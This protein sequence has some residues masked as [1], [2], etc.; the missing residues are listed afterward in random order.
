MATTDEWGD[1][2]GTVVTSL[3]ERRIEPVPDSIVKQAQRSYEG[4]AAGT[5]DD[6]KPILRHALQHEF[7]TP[8][9]AA[10]F[11]AHMRNAGPHVITADGHG[12]SV[13][14]TV[15]PERKR[16]PA[17]DENGQQ[18][19]ADNGKAVTEPGP[20]VNPRLVRWRAG[21]PR[22]RKPGS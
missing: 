9:R 18:K 13:T 3:R 10:R 19:Y 4:V 21:A 14:V 12:A 7:E 2:E 1:F 11:A 17:L 5:D 20:A 6:G 15:D 16:V 22:G 8:E